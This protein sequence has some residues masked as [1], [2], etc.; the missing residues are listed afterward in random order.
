MRLELHSEITILAT[1]SGDSLNFLEKM[2]LE[3]LKTFLNGADVAGMTI[4]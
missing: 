4:V 3:Q 1:L 2:V